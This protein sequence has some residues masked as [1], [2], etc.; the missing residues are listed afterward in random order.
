VREFARGPGACILCARFEGVDER[1]I[2][3]ADWRSLVGDYI[4]RRR[5][6]GAGAD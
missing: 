5:I 3:R 6:A 1:V 2:P 4:L